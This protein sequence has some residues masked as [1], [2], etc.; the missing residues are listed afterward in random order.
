VAG[1][2]NVTLRFGLPSET[3]FLHLLGISVL[4]WLYN[5]SGN[6]AYLLEGKEER[7]KKEKRKLKEKKN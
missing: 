3:Y 7:K 5:S 1:N 2:G 4:H 6:K